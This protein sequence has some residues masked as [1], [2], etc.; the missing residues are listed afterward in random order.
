MRIGIIGTGNMGRA[1]GLRWARARHDVFFGSRDLSKAEAI[2]AS[3]PDSAR[4]GDLDA[5]AGF[6]DVVLYTVRDV[7]PSDLLRNPQVLAG[8]IVID[9]NNSAILGLDTSDPD[10][11]AGVHFTMPFPSLA[12]RLAADTK[13]ARVV[14]AFNTIPSKIIELEREKLAP[15]RVSVF[16]CSDDPQAKAVV[17]GLAEELGFVGVDSGELKRAQ[18]V[19]AVADFIRFQILGMGL[20]PFATISVHLLPKP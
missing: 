19:E 20:G 17:S 18:L 1:L 7:F 16:L 5:A 8:K 13:G 15:H 11:R 4:A 12:E 3:G 9:C 2:A 14:K 6:G 10:H